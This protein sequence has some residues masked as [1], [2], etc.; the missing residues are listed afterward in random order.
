MVSMKEI[1]ISDNLHDVIDNYILY[2]NLPS[3]NTWDE[4]E[5]MVIDYATELNDLRDRESIWQKMVGKK[6]VDKEKLRQFHFVDRVDEILTSFKG[7]FKD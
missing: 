3:G 5:Q 7:I 6:K 4:I 1:D 2:G